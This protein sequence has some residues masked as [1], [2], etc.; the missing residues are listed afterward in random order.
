MRNLFS[1]EGAKILLDVILIIFI[2][3]RI[4]TEQGFSK[5]FAVSFL[6]F[7]LVSLGLS[8]TKLLLK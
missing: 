7:T 2:V 8:A 6:A 1:L 5:T 4:A 3:F